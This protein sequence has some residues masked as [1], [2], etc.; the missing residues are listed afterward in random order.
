MLVKIKKLDPKAT[1][2][3]CGSTLSAGYDVYACLPE[4]ISIPPHQTKVISTGL[5]IEPPSGYYFALVARSGLA[6]KQG[7]RLANCYAVCDEDYRG[8]YKVPL[9][10]D[11]DTPRKIKSGDRI[12]QMILTAYHTCEFSEVDELSDTSRGTGGFGSTGTR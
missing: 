4:D 1:I 11:S 10:N 3:T 12:A 5:A 9:Y 7:L 8:E 2:P 6:T